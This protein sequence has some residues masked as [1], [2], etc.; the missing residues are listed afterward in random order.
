MEFSDWP[1]CPEKWRI[2]RTKV[3]F[4]DDL[5][6]KTD[7]FPDDYEP[8]WTK[9]EKAMLTFSFGVPSGILACASDFVDYEPCGSR[10]HWT[11]KEKAMLT[12]SFRVPS[13]IRTHDIQNHNLTL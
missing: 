2:Y 7:I 3:T 8:H 1:A 9:K 5:S 11:K 4:C 12:F 10:T 6:G 13:G